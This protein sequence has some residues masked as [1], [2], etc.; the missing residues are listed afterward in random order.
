[1]A[2]RMPFLVPAPAPPP[3]SQPAD[4][5]QPDAGSGGKQQNEILLSS[6]ICCYFSFE[7]QLTLFIEIEQGQRLNTLLLAVLL[8]LSY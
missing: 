2:D 4:W 3:P 5:I 6:F 7:E 8:V 1:M